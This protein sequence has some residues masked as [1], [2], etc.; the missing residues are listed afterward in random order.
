VKVSAKAE[1]ACVAMVELAIKHPLNQPVQ[2]K[3]IAQIHG[4]S[5]RFL[6]QILLQLKAAGLVDSSRGAAG[7]YQLARPPE[8]ITLANIVHVID[9]AQ[10]FP[11]ALNSLPRSLVVQ[12][13]RTVWGSVSSAELAIL[14]KTRL[15]NLVQLSQEQNFASYQI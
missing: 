11:S 9:R 14:E 12:A 2:I 5:P 7:G 3:N 15:S 6:V 4:I 13:L 1:Y 8:E 10:E